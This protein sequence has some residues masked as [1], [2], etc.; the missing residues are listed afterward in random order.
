MSSFTAETR[1]GVFATIT[2]ALL[3]FGLFWLNGG[4]IIDPG[5][6]IEVVFNNVNGLRPGSPVKL[7][8]VDIGRI[9]KVYFA[10]DQRIIV[11]AW[12]K[13]KIMIREDSKAVITTA[14][15][16]GDNYLEILPGKSPKAL[17]MG[18][19]LI[20]QNPPSTEEFYRSAYEIMT[21]LKQIVASIS[22]IT[23][24]QN[25]ADSIQN[26]LRNI[27]SF[28][29][30][31][32][33]FSGRMDAL[34]LESMLGKLDRTL[35][36]IEQIAH[37]AG[38]GVT[39]IIKQMTQA[40][41]QLTLVMMKANRFLDEVN[42]DGEASAKVRQILDL[43]AKTMSDLEAFSATLAQ[44]KDHI[45]P[46]LAEAE[47][48]AKS[49]TAAANSIQKAVDGL[50]SAEGSNLGKKLQ[51][52][53]VM[54]DKAH[55][56]L[57]ALE[58]QRIGFSGNEDQ[59]GLDYRLDTYFGDRSSIIFDWQS[60]GKSNDLSLTYGYRFSDQFRGRVGYLHEDAG[61]GLDWQFSPKWSLSLNAWDPHDLQSELLLN[62]QFND[63][64]HF[65][66]GGYNYNDD[67]SYAWQFGYWF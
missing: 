21:S 33:D 35:D 17:P 11:Q 30:N 43:A 29:A 65:G 48:T 9:K 32:N 46:L 57:K 19:R 45:G 60:I 63:H 7:A 26:S 67:L 47:T 25:F 56:L 1:V 36:H 16:I 5:Y 39:H 12:L 44:E 10:E 58:H 18:K 20:G 40:S 38:P 13:P 49:I 61:L 52:A 37:E 41:N 54:V 53:G 59:W 22:R 23:N 28:T 15:V 4:R 27:E 24:D 2:L 64:W 34:P 55:N 62:F 42:G 3:G 14:G 6:P 31:L 50:T 66:L 8:G 51:D